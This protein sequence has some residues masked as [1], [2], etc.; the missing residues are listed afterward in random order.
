M[1]KYST[2]KNTKKTP[3]NII[4]AQNGVFLCFLMFFC[5]FYFLNDFRGFFT[6]Y[7]VKH[8]K[9]TKTTRKKQTLFFA[10]IVFFLRVFLVFLFFD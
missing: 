10:E 8:R 5:V 6:I 1:N 2:Q 4:S 3:K 9:N 7:D